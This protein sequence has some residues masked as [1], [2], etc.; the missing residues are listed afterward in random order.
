[1]KGAIWLKTALGWG[2]VMMCA[3]LGSTS[4]GALTLKEACEWAVYHTEWQPIFDQQLAQARGNVRIAQ[5][6]LYPNITLAYRSFNVGFGPAAPLTIVS[7]YIVFPYGRNTLQVQ[8]QEQAVIITQLNQL[9]T[10]MKI[11]QS[12][13]LAYFNVQ[14]SQI[15][16]AHLQ[17]LKRVTQ[18]RL[19]E[20]RQWVA[21]G[22][23]KSTDALA[24]E[25][26]IGQIEATIQNQTNDL[27]NRLKELGFWVDKPITVRDLSP[28]TPAHK[29]YGNHDV[30]TGIHRPDIKMIEE[31]VTQLH[32]QIKLAELMKWPS[33]SMG[34]I[35]Q[36]L[37]ALVSYTLWDYGALD[38]QQNQQTQRA[39]ELN[40]LLD[41]QKRL[42]QKDIA[43]A[44]QDWQF[45]Q[46]QVGL[47]QKN[48]DLSQRFLKTLQKEYSQHLVSNLEVIQATRQWYQSTLDM[49]LGTLA[50]QRALALF[51]I[52][53][54]G[55]L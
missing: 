43:I 8:N 22:R 47:L 30:M 19:Q 54:E 52:E 1:M 46:K 17:E 31:Q 27:S 2:V 42:V 26:E 35:N 55:S 21:I 14:N 5:S 37:M 39:S 34:V 10:K 20:V 4:V 53:Q 12:V 11:Q 25:M 18:Q 38:A 36:N 16:L 13:V 15:T 33:I 32:I 6:D 45:C 50:T 28:W 3:C 44:Y 29:A 23:S 41:R 9:S 24:V 48:L 51:L 49:S 7:D 40:A